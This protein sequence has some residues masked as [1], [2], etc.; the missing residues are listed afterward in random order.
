MV[1]TE[2]E[3]TTFITGES[4]LF[5]SLSLGRATCD[6]ALACSLMDLIEHYKKTAIISDPLVFL[7]EPISVRGPAMDCS[8]EVT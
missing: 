6:R 5:L 2:L 1:S 7:T 3:K 8:V 4:S